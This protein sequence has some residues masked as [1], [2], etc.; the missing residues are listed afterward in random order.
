MVEALPWFG[1]GAR[2]IIDE[3]GYCSRGAR[4]G[5]RQHV[6]TDD[7]CVSPS[8]VQPDADLS[9]LC[10]EPAFL[11]NLARALGPSSPQITAFMD[12]SNT[13][14]WT[15]RTRETLFMVRTTRN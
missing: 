13:R 2:N 7:V 14:K 3:S 8:V 12:G 6:M 1:R 5:R 11:L 10:V 9:A 4:F 15:F